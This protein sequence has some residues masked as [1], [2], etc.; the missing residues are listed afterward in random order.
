MKKTVLTFGLISGAI[1]T[2]LMFLTI[3]FLG[4]LSYEYLTI[5]G[6]TIF[7]VCFLMVFFGIRSVRDNVAGGTITFGKGF[8]VGLLITLISCAIYIVSWEIISKIFLPNF[9]EQYLAYTI[10][11]LRAAGA[12]PEEI[13]RQMQENEKFLRWYKNPLIR[14]AMAF[15][16][17]FPVGLLITLISALILRRKQRKGDLAETRA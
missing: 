12:A 5:L 8:K 1:A 6:Y 17:A 10:E 14:Y 9:F 15:M 11:K 16:E 13:S 2:L 3:R 4:R 7:V